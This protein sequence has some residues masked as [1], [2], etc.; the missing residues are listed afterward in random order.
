MKGGKKMKAN[1]LSVTRKSINVFTAAAVVALFALFLAPGPVQAD[2]ISNLTYVQPT[3][4][5]G[6][7]DSVTVWLKFSLD[8]TSDPLYSDASGLI[9]SH[10]ILNGLDLI[11]GSLTVGISGF[12]NPPYDFVWGPSPGPTQDWDTFWAQFHNLNLNA[13][14]SFIYAST[15]YF[16]SAGPVPAGTYS[17][18]F[19]GFAVWGPDQFQQTDANGNLVFDAD[20]NPVMQNYLH[21]IASADNTFS[22]TVVGTTA[23][24]EPSTMLLLGIG[25]AG[26][27]GLRRKCNN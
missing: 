26:L 1:S 22:R 16:P 14:D 20:G 2:L 4:T 17:T 21:Y 11:G 8:P 24:P 6:P 12:P 9:T 23:V 3:G 25:L 18:L 5:V 19:D 7:N 27:V 13:G 10:S 15:T